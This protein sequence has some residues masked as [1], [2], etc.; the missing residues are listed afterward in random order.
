MKRIYIVLN[1]I[2][3]KR[4]HEP[5]HEFFIVAEFDSNERPSADG[6]VPNELL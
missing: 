1:E 3:Q 5:I 4:I 2:I 6:Y